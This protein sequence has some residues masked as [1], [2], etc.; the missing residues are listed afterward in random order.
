MKTGNLCG[1][2]DFSARRGAP[3]IAHNLAGKFTVT[4]GRLD[5]ASPADM[6]DVVLS[7]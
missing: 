6:H 2:S 7:R 5:I 4:G 3:A 1:P